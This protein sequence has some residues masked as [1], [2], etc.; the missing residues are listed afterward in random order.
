MFQQTTQKT[1]LTSALNIF[2]LVY[3][4]IVRNV[5]KSHGNAVLSIVMDMLQAIIFVLA[6]YV[7][8]S[9]L[10]LRSAALRGDFLI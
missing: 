10:G 1:T 6:F 3:H 9:V 2:E 8:S 7:M 4:S 5:R